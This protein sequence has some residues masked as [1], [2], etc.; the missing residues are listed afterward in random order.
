L[1]YR[2][3]NWPASRIFVLGCGGHGKTTQLLELLKVEKAEWFF[4]F[5]HKHEIGR[6]LGKP[7]VYTLDGIIKSTARGGWVV[8]DPSVMFPGRKDDAFAF[9]CDF[10]FQFASTTKGRKVVVCDEIQQR[11]SKSFLPPELKL[12]LDDGRQFQIDMRA[13]GQASNSIHNEVRHQITEVYAFRHSDRNGV[14]WLE[15]NG[16]DGAEVQSLKPGE[17]IWRD[18]ANGESRRGGKAFRIKSART[19]NARPAPARRDVEKRG[20]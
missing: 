10:V 9:F 7:Y 18:L 20:G 2:D 8:F 17:Y 16:F 14:A 15:D 19:S 12:I 1:T 3:F 11:M 13:A 4:V 5:D 6:R